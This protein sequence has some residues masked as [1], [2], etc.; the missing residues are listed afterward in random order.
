MRERVI[1]AG[2]MV[3]ALLCATPAGAVTLPAAS[4]VE[5]L[6]YFRDVWAA[7][8][9]SYGDDAR[10]RMVAFIDDHI[11]HARSMERYDLALIFAEAQAL[12]GNSHTESEFFAVDGLFHPL[13]IS[14]WLFPEGAIVTRACPEFRR[15]LGAKIVRIGGVPVS[16]AAHRC[17]KL[18]AGT[19]ERK[20]YM[21]PA[22]LARIEVLEAIGLASNGVVRVELELPSGRMVTERLSAAS[23]PDPAAAAEPW[24]ASMVPGK[25]PSAWPHVLDGLSKL[26]LY[27]QEPNEFTSAPLDDGRVLYVRSNSLTPYEGEITV[28]LKA[29]LIMDGVVKSGQ[30][31]S[32]VVVDLRYN[33]G[34][35]FLNITNFT[36]ELVG[37]V[38]PQGHIYVITGR[39]T[40]SAAIAFTAL[41]K[42]GAAGRSKIVGEEPSDNPWFWSE[43]DKLMAPASKLPMRFTT[44]FHDWA[45]GCKD[46]TKC[47][48]PLVFHGVAAGSLLPDIPVDMTFA[49]YVAG[50]DPALEAVLEDIRGRRA[51]G[52]ARR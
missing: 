20:K 22:W 27:L 44:G 1:A 36:T 9:R 45:H 8:D 39:A 37:L 51:A 14:F 16:E 42:A 21:A 11:A 7:K 13:P 47:Y 19:T 15:L 52:A 41:L 6:R 32:D 35:N 34:G 3:G 38:G 46:L 28:Q 23:I 24:Q 40:Y 29:Y 50:R 2:V 5:D 48:W 18:I 10:A 31:P 30:V 25:A 26:P 17:D 49:E 43:G 12:S 4:V 33:G